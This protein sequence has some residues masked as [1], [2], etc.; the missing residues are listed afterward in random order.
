MRH[1]TPI[2]L[3]GHAATY[4]GTREIAGKKHN[5]TIVTML[6][7]VGIRWGGDET[8]WCAAFVNWVLN[9]AGVDG[10]SSAMARSFSR[11]G[12]SVPL[13]KALPGDVAVLWRK[14][15]KSSSGHVGFIQS[16]TDR[17]VTLLGGNQGNRV[18]SKRYPLRRLLGVRRQT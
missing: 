15:P 12:D 10:T 1:P 11:W 4:L 16:V 17:H 18:S 3:L 8:P 6:R 9:D 13:A 2:E 7:H 14:D 5:P